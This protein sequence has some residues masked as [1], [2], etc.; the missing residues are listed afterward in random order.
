MHGRIR[1]DRAVSYASLS[2][3]AGALFSPL[4]F[5]LAVAIGY[6][7]ARRGRLSGG[8]VMATGLLFFLVVQGYD[9]GKTL[10]LRD[11]ARQAE[12]HASVR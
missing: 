9:M 3:V 6:P 11:N 1:S 4:F 7:A 12:A 2:I 5:L 10:A 8:L